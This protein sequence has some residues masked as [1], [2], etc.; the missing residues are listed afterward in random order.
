MLLQC[1]HYFSLSMLIIVV[2]EDSNR[3]KHYLRKY[4]LPLLK[5]LG[6]FPPWAQ[7]IGKRATLSIALTL[8]VVLCSPYI[9]SFL[10]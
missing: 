2:Y 3:S 1:F 5:E 10:S 6:K 4:C 7:V 8:Q 9:L